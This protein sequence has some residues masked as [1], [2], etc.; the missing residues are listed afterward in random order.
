HQ[1]ILSYSNFSQE[2]LVIETPL[3][4]PEPKVEAPRPAELPAK[5]MNTETP[6][7]AA[8]KQSTSKAKAKA[9]DILNKIEGSESS[10]AQSESKAKSTV[11]AKLEV[12]EKLKKTEFSV[13][14]AKAMLAAQ[15]QAVEQV[16][17]TAKNK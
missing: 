11:S 2:E 14:E 5:S 10:F 9:S 1:T 7:P 4:V 13:E 3:F 17:T 12:S 16:E 15:N 8:K 6:A